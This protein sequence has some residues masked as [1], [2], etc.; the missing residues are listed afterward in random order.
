MSEP[1]LIIAGGGPAGA[2]A[3]AFREHH[4]GASVRTHVSSRAPR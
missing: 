4:E 3:E 2:A 1:G